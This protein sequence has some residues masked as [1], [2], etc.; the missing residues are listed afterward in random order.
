MT[1]C[2]K[3][4]TNDG[5]KFSTNLFRGIPTASLTSVAAIMN[6][7]GKPTIND[8]STP[9][10]VRSQWEKWYRCPIKS[11][12]NLSFKSTPQIP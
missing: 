3:N 8:I 4:I 7:A 10:V 6:Y 1:D 11:D 5:M 12:F 9:V 2:S